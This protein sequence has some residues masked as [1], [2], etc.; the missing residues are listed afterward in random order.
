MGLQY[1]YGQENWHLKI[2]RD[3][4]AL[5]LT[6]QKFSKYSKEIPLLDW[7]TELSWTHSFPSRSFKEAVLPFVISI[8]NKNQGQI[9]L[10]QEWKGVMQS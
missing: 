2:L 7:S 9:K 8:P 4:F 10:K 3:F 5:A 6:V 1:G